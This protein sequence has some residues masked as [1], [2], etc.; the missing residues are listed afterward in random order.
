MLTG[1]DVL[2]V[3]G[4]D[5]DIPVTITLDQGRT[6]N[7]TESWKWVLRRTVEG[8]DLLTKVQPTQI[9]I[10]NSPGF[11]PTVHLLAADFLAAQ[12]PD[13]IDPQHYIHELQMT[14]DSKV[15][16]VLRGQF[17]V[18]SDVVAV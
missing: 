17:T 8:T 18:L 16:T 7:G 6:L 15:E 1:Q 3:R 2:H 13:K 11:N 10:G 12:F 9:T 4:D 5:L 14:K